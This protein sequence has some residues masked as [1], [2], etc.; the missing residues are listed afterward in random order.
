MLLCRSESRIAT[1]IKHRTVRVHEGSTQ[2]SGTEACSAPTGRHTISAE[3]WRQHPSRTAH[4]C[5]SK[6]LESKFN[7]GLLVM[8]TTGPYTRICGLPLSSFYKAV[9]LVITLLHRPGCYP[10]PFSLLTR[11]SS[12]FLISL[13][14]QTPHLNSGLL[15]FLTRYALTAST[16]NPGFTILTVKLN[17]SQSLPSRHSSTFFVPVILRTQ[18]FSHMCSFCCCCRR[19]THSVSATVSRPH[20][21]AGVTHTLSVPPSQDHISM[22]ALH[23]LC[24]CR[25]LKTT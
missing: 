18:L 1:G 12:S 2:C 23:T 22:P 7:L 11:S 13:L 14:T 17:V 25:R 20:K 9:M 8:V 3:L 6:R 24:Q 10:F 16:P 15:F 21:H 4:I 5:W 19:Y